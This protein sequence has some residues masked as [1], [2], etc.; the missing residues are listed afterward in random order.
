[1]A[2]GHLR[3]PR[4][5][6]D[7]EYLATA[8]L[9]GPGGYAGAYP[10]IEYVTPLAH[11]QDGIDHGIGVGR[12][13]PLVA[14]GFG[15]EGLGDVPSTMRL[16]GGG[17]VPYGVSGHVPIIMGDCPLSLGH[18]TRGGSL[19]TGVHLPDARELLFAAAERVLGRD[20]P[21]AV[22]SRAVTDEAGVAKGVMH[23]HFTDFDSFLAELVIDRVA[24]LNGQLAALVERAGSGEVTD[25]LV[26]ALADVFNPLAVAIL[27]LVVTREGLRARLREAGAARLPLLTEGSTAISQYLSAEQALGRVAR[28]ADA[29]TLS[30]VLLG[31]AH[32]LFTDHETGPPDKAALQ[33]LVRGV[34][35]GWLST[36]R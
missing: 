26:S 5:R 35:H 30:H 32:L 2:A 16:I 15:A 6:L 4:V 8:L 12:P 11:R 24:R 14:L 21:S 29:A 33:A 13:R 25:N 34:M 27:A 31:A 28:D 9:E 23:R 3:H 36:D 1:M 19:P 18:L 7:T 20:G 22:T 10:H 17:N